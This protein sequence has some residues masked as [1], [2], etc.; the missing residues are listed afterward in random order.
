MRSAVSVARQSRRHSPYLK[1]PSSLGL[2][3][4]LEGLKIDSVSSRTRGMHIKNGKVQGGFHGW[5]KH[6]QRLEPLSERT[7]LV[8]AA[9][10][11]PSGRVGGSRLALPPLSGGLP[12]QPQPPPSSSSAASSFVLPSL[13]SAA[14]AEGG[15]RARADAGSPPKRKS[16]RPPKE[17]REAGG[18]SSSHKARERKQRVSP[19][20]AA[21][22]EEEAAAPRAVADASERAR[23]VR[24][25]Q[26]Y[27]DEVRQ[28]PS[29]ASELFL[30]AEQGIDAYDGKEIRGRLRA[31]FTAAASEADAGG[32]GGGEMR[33]LLRPTGRTPTLSRELFALFTSRLAVATAEPRADDAHIAERIFDGL[34]SGGRGAVSSEQA[35]PPLL[36]LPQP[37]VPLIATDCH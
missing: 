34:D 17:P 18:S 37:R 20:A 30:K 15:R 7:P 36:T 2:S 9:E 35:R 22:S 14:A 12:P 24:M 8:S 21:A 3:D 5:S 32:S 6:Q 25:L 1:P 23:I 28:P 29:P 10:P 16:P 31:A 11:G 27:E 33:S 4:P 13:T 19:A 26:E